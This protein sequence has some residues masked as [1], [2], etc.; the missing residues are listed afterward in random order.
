MDLITTII[1]VSFLF[2]NLFLD[3]PIIDMDPII[4]SQILSP[5]SL[6]LTCSFEG[7]PLPSIS[8]IR[9][10]DGSYTVFNMSTT[11]E[12]GRTLTIS[13]SSMSNTVTS[14]FTIVST[15]VVDTANYMCMATN[16]LS[17]ENSTSSMV[18]VYGKKQY[19]YQI[20]GTILGVSD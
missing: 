10:R 12:D 14:N 9:T 7:F 6:S 16:I 5:Q 19:F 2:V 11:E 8:W 3:A 1:V 4:I 18:F 17:S 20:N 15:R 13:S